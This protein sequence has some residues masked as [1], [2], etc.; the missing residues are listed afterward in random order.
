MDDGTG[1]NKR[2]TEDT[3]TDGSPWLEGD[4]TQRMVRGGTWD[5]QAQWLRS[6][7][8]NSMRAASG[9]GMYGFRVVRSLNAAM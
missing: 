5:W 9:A 1:F 7:A 8:R 6:G 2:Y 3:P 4:C